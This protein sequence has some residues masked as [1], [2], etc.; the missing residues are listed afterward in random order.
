[1]CRDVEDSLFR[2]FVKM[3]YQGYSSDFRVNLF[4]EFVSYIHSL[5]DIDYLCDFEF[6]DC[7]KIASNLANLFGIYDKI[8][9]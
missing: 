3:S 1:M 4:R 5:K 7:I 8:G 6:D 9:F 2:Y